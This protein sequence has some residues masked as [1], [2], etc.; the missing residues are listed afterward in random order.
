MVETLSPKL[1]FPPFPNTN[2][3]AFCEVV[4]A[5]RLTADSRPAVLGT[6]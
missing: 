6:V 4:P 1:T 2:A 5:E 3:L